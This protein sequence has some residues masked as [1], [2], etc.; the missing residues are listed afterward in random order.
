MAEGL[1]RSGSMRLLHHAACKI[2]MIRLTRNREVLFNTD[3]PAAFVKCQFDSSAVCAC[4][5][6]TSDGRRL[7]VRKA[8][9]NYHNRLEQRRII[10]ENSSF[11]AD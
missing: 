10:D 2:K 4:L 11:C 1:N 3:L 9:L 7:V 8:E 5:L 6:Y